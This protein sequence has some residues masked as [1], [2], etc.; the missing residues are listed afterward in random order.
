[1]PELIIIDHTG[2]T[3]SIWN[4][5]ND[6]EVEAARATFNALKKK[7]YIGYR[8][9]PGGDKGEILHEFDPNAEKVI[10]APPVAGG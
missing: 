1:M 8:V 7:G 4:P 6:A 3:K 10:L 9:Q 2:D 5:Q